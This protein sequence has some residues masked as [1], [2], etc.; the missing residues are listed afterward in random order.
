MSVSL[1]VWEWASGW[2]S[3]FSSQWASGLESWSGLESGSGL[4]FWSVSE[5]WSPSVFLSM[6][7][8]SLVWSNWMMSY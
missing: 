1:P 2:V 7:V 3:A 5:F 4:E 6:S 8:F